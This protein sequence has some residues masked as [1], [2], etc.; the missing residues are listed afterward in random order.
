M[1][2]AFGIDR[3]LDERAIIDLRPLWARVKQAAFPYLK[4]QE[5]FPSDNFSAISNPCTALANPG[6]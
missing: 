1:V 5:S 2:A 4:F 6:L 3:A